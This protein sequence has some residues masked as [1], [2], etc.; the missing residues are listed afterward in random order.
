MLEMVFLT[1]RLRQFDLFTTAGMPLFPNTAETA[2]ELPTLPNAHS[3][4][5]GDYLHHNILVGMSNLVAH[6]A[7]EKEKEKFLKSAIHYLILHEMG[8]TLGLMHNMKASNLW[9]PSEI[10]DASK[11]QTLGLIGSVM[12]YPAVNINPDHSHQGDYYTSKPGPYD[13]WAIEYG[14]SPSLNNPEEEETR[15]SAILERSTEKEL[16]FGN[17][18][19]DMRSAGKGIDPRVM[20]F[21]ISGDAVTY[22]T[23]RIKMLN[24]ILPKL[25]EKYS[26]EGNGYQELL[27]S[28]LTVTGEIGNASSV[29]S[30]YV[31]GVYVERSVVGQNGEKIPY[32]P[33]PSEKQKQAIASLNELIFSPDAFKASE[34]LY[35]YLQAQRRGFNFFSSTEDPKIHE[36]MLNI[37]KNVLNHVLHKNTLDRVTNSELYG[38]TYSVA[39]ILNDLDKGIFDA[40]LNGS[41]N[42]FRMNL[43]N[44][45]VD[46]LIAIAGLEKKSSHNSISQ[47][48]AYASLVNIQKKLKTATGKG[49]LASQAHRT[50]LY[51]TIEKA[52]AAK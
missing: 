2:A 24:Q 13:L 11:T 38:N 34:N 44:E 27:V 40:D 1:G 33:V 50:Y 20:I 8:H 3:C 16:T 10:H 35:R 17:D 21:D 46:Q 4:A 51:Y 7:D 49:N 14:Y 18:A 5:A 26:K 31:G 19:D 39:D 48:A 22:S 47:A 28:Y 41:L 37:Q 6:E 45:Y 42:T 52:L 36:R 15:L 30:R 43:Q 29:I 23:D 32:T 12:D 9:M 25:K